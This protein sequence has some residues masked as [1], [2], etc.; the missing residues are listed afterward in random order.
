MLSGVREIQKAINPFRGKGYALVPVIEQLLDPQRAKDVNPERDLLIALATAPSE[1]Q[2]AFYSATSEAAW[3]NYL[4]RNLVARIRS[5]SS[6]IP[7]GHD[8]DGAFAAWQARDAHQRLKG[9]EENHLKQLLQKIP[10]ARTPKELDRIFR[11]VPPESF[12]EVDH[13]QA[14]QIVDAINSSRKSEVAPSHLDLLHSLFYH[15]QGV[16][17]S[18]RDTIKEKLA[19]SDPLVV[20]L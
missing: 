13:D 11:A 2:S 20:A 10:D 3:H 6:K 4:P 19:S 1:L 14:R 18:Y 12:A 7:Q 16:F 17:G 9:M 15:A 5:L 8:A